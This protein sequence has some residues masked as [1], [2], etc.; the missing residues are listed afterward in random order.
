VTAEPFTRRRL[1]AGAGVLAI[2][3]ALAAC[4]SSARRSSPPTSSGP[5][6]SRATPAQTNPYLSGNF[7]PV[8]RELTATELEVSGQIPAALTG[9]F[10]R[11]GPNPVTNPTGN[12]SWFAGDGM[13]HIVELDAGRAVSYRNRW[14]RTPAVAKALGEAP[15][16]GP[17]SPTFVDVSNT[18]TGLLGGSLVSVTESALPYDVGFDGSTIARSN[19]G[20]GLTHGLSA[21]SKYDPATGE[22][23]QIG[24]RATPAPYVVWQVIDATT[25][26][27]KSTVPVDVAKPIMV[28]TMTLTP[29]H[30]LVYDLRVVFSAAALSAGWVPYAW[31]PSY[32]ARLG[33]ISRATGQVQWIDLPPL[34]I[35][36]DGGSHDTS[37][38]LSVDVVTYPKV[39]DGDLAGPL[40]QPT[41]LERW[42]VDTSK[43]TVKRTIIDDRPQEFP[44]ISPA[45][46]GRAARYTYTVGAQSGSGFDALATN[47]SVLRHDSLTGATSRWSVGPNRSSAEAVFVADPDRSGSEDGG[48]LLSF[49]FDSTT[50]RSSLVVLDAEDVTAG[51][52]ASIGLPQR[53]PQGFHGNWFARS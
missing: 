21:H 20:G 35:F 4:S 26:L 47:N 2:G 41:Q 11:N 37:T 36:H 49:V 12:Y 1:L 5:L 17:P 32:Q 9:Y 53:V 46:F 38:G 18:N 3:G 34:W 33:V 19:P 48:W 27:V 52:V 22:I 6:P 15:P 31:D 7:A 40:G 44:R 24:Y 29:E 23:H 14:V 13:L 25:G 42:S 43:G 30:V 51:P 8:T 50:D 39:F 16:T 10:V 45:T 28:H